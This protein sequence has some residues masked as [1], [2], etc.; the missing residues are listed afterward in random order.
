MD[1]EKIWNFNYPLLP[2]KS[3]AS[4]TKI[5]QSLRNL[6]YNLKAEREV[7][8]YSDKYISSI[9]YEDIMST[10]NIELMGPELVKMYGAEFSKDVDVIQAEMDDSS[11]TK[12]ED[13]VEDHSLEGGHDYSDYFNDEDELVDENNAGAHEALY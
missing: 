4:E 2:Q 3:I 8:R 9:C 5:K 11:S 7:E 1:E 10:V 13:G 12:A 6:S